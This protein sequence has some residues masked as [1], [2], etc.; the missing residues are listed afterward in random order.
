MHTYLY[1]SERIRNI[2]FLISSLLHTVLRSHHIFRV[3]RIDMLEWQAHE[4][5][6]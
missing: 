3:L 1:T 2:A 5:I 6:N 4:Y